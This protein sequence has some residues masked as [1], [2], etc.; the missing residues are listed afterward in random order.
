MEGFI[1]FA[2]FVLVVAYLVYAGQSG[3]KKGKGRN[4]SS[5]HKYYSSEHR[6]YSE[7]NRDYSK[8]KD[9]VDPEMFERQKRRMKLHFSEK[10]FEDFYAFLDAYEGGY[11]K[12]KNGRI[13]YREYL[14]REKGDLKGIFFNL[15]IPNENITTGQKEKFR[16]LL[17]SIGVSGVYERPMY[18]SRESKLTNRKKDEVEYAIKEIGNKGE[19]A[20]RDILDTLNKEHYSVINGPVLE[21][22]EIMKEFDHIIVGDTGVFAI[23]TKAFGMT[24]GKDTKATLTISDDIWTVSTGGPEHEKNNPGE[25]ISEQQKLLQSIISNYPY[26]VHSVLL[27]SNKLIEISQKNMPGYDVIKVDELIDYITGYPDKVYYSDRLNM[28]VDIDQ[29]RKN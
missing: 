13:V 15:V 26:D 20:V 17:V 12:R 23:E 5:N 10:E 27:L 29:C 7:G 8:K 9:Y 18:E 24:D 28:I 2:V 25:Q 22:N 21:K 4:Y 6:N 14:N 1:A 16:L 3:R 19:K 11:V